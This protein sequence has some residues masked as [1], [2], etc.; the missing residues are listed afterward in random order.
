MDLGKNVER[1]KKIKGAL[2]VF[3]M[4]FIS[5][6]ATNFYCLLFLEEFFSYILILAEEKLENITF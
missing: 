6:H 3:L 2:S 4:L 5:R 1:E